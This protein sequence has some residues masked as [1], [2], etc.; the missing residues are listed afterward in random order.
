MRALAA[1][2]YYS[3]FSKPLRM[4]H[5]IDSDVCTDIIIHIP[6]LVLVL[7]QQD[8]FRLAIND[9][10][11]NYANCSFCTVAPHHHYIQLVAD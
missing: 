10:I 5:I 8:T 9:A 6:H 7:R 2:Y 1:I 4:H 3:N 11:P